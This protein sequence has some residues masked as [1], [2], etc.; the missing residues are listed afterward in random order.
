[1][2][3]YALKGLPISKDVR[4][5]SIAKQWI[6]LDSDVLENKKFTHIPMC[7]WIVLWTYFPNKYIM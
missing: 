4:Y 2:Q 7:F 5:N 1:M 3:A 6:L